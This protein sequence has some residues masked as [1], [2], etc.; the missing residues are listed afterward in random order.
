M[1]GLASLFVFCYVYRSALAAPSNVSDAFVGLTGLSGTVFFLIV[2]ALFL[3]RAVSSQPYV[4]IT[5]EGIYDNGSGIWAGAGWIDWDE[6]ADIRVSTYNG[7]PSVELIPLDKVEF[8]QRFNWIERIDRISSRYPP[9]VFRPP[10]LS[11]PEDVLA[12]QLRAYWEAA[13]RPDNR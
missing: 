10:L 4:V 7:R 2:S 9:V 1:M 3:R 12:E 8:M 11:I 13:T 5:S 6:V